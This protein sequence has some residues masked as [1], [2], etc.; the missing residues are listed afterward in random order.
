MRLGRRDRALRPLAATLPLAGT[1]MALL[2]AA[3]LLEDGSDRG[4]VLLAAGGCGPARGSRSRA[5]TARRARPRHGVP[6]P[7]GRGDR[8]ARVGRR[9]DPRLGRAGHPPLCLASRLRDARLSGGLVYL[10]LAIGHAL[11]VDAPPSSIP[12]RPVPRRRRRVDRS[13]LRRAR[14]ARR[15]RRCPRPS[16]VVATETGVSP[17]SRRFGRSSR[18]IAA[19]RRRS[20]SRPACSTCSR[21][22]A[23]LTGLDFEAGHIA[24]LAIASQRRL[25]PRSRSRRANRST[26]STRAPRSWR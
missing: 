18:H 4:L 14:R 10:A 7:R 24:A 20:S 22:A 23:L 21:S 8:R 9:A 25:P 12:V 1:G 11:V 16:R 26:T 2:T 13:C 5:E 17:S 3:E 19:F 15:R 6:R